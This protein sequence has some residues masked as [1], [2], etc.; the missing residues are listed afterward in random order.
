MILTGVDRGGGG[1]ERDDLQWKT[2]GGLSRKCKIAKL[3]KKD[4]IED[5]CEDSIYVMNDDVGW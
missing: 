4:F 1:G 3:Q 2:S 5:K